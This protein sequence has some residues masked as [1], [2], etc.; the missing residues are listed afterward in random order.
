MQMPVPTEEHKRLAQLAGNWTGE[1]ITHPTPWDPNKSRAVGRI[2]ARIDLGGFFLITD[3]E[4]EKD[5]QVVF[6]GHG[7]YGYDPRGKCYTMHWFDSSGTEHGAP[8]LGSWDG[9][10][11][12]LQHETGHL[13][14]TRYVYQVSDAE[15]SLR[16]EHS[17]DGRNWTLFLEG[18]YRRNG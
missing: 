14:T 17:P 6:R 11:L 16:I 8:A 1:E 3:N 9:N 15:L 10:T 5:G 2:R 7:V 13:G 18:R 4:H 12:T